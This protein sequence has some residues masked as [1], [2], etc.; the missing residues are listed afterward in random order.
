MG[1]HIRPITKGTYG[2]LSKVREELE[3]AEDAEAQGQKLILLTE[4]ADIV[5]AVEG[6]AIAHGFTLDDLLKYA[7]LRSE[8]ARKSLVL[9]GGLSTYGA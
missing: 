6:V 3:E 5:G 7:R 1:F 8:I 4:L 9:T 2:E